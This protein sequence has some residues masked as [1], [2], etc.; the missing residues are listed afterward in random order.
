[1]SNTPVSHRDVTPGLRVECPR[2][3]PNGSHLATVTSVVPVGTGPARSV[4]SLDCGH[5][6]N[7]SDGHCLYMPSVCVCG[8]EFVSDKGM[9]AHRGARGACPGVKS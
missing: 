2:S 5:D 8:R 3:V 4:V 1:M 6:V 7:M 9:R